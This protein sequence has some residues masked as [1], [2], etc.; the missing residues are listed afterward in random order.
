MPFDNK[1]VKSY[2][3]F[4]VFKDCGDAGNE[5]KLSNLA[6]NKQFQDFPTKNPT[7]NMVKVYRDSF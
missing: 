1:M 6:K 4:Q 3:I 2:F 5:L 7:W